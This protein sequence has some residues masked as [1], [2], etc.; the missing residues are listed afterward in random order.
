MPPSPTTTNL[1]GE[2]CHGIIKF[3]HVILFLSDPS[4]ILALPCPFLL[5]SRVGEMERASVMYSVAV[6]V[7]MRLRQLVCHAVAALLQ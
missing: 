6:A 1:P 5:E 4:P 2:L 3:S 7:V